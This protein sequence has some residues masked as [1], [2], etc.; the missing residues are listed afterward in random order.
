MPEKLGQVDER[1]PAVLA[2][3]GLVFAG[4]THSSVT[5]GHLARSFHT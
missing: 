3:Q 4:Q 5:I 2:G 1:A